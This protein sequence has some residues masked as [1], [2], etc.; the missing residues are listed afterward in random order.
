MGGGF[1][2]TNRKVKVSALRRGQRKQILCINFTQLVTINGEADVV[3]RSYNGLTFINEKRLSNTGQGRFGGFCR[4]RRVLT[5]HA[6]LA[7]DM[8]ASRFRTAAKSGF[9]A[10]YCGKYS[11]FRSSGHLVH[12]SSSRTNPYTQGGAFLGCWS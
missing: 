5:A 3:V 7:P 1:I 4:P 9:K 6:P 12:S 2:L 10:C 8:A 11:Q